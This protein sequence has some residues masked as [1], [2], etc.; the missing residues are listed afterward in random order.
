MTQLSEAFLD[1]EYSYRNMKRL[2]RGRLPPEH[3][4][5]RG[6]NFHIERRKWS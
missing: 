4:D 1:E 5:F 6:Y 2:E 3:E